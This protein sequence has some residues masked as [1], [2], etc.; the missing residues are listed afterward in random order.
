[1]K[2][3]PSLYAITRVWYCKA[4]KVLQMLLFLLVFLRMFRNV[5]CFG[6]AEAGACGFSLPATAHK[7]WSCA[8]DH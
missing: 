4:E 2:P 7:F 5:L 1:M 6:R 8:V 3:P